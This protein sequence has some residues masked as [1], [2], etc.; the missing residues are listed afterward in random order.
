MT[1][2]YVHILGWILSKVALNTDP[3]ITVPYNMLCMMYI[4]TSPLVW[5]QKIQ[6][7]H[8]RASQKKEYLYI[9]HSRKFI[10]MW[11]SHCF[12]LLLWTHSRSL[13]FY[14][15]LWMVWNSL[16][17]MCSPNAFVGWQVGHGS[18]KWLSSEQNWWKQVEGGKWAD[19]TGLM[20]NQFSLLLWVQPPGFLY[21]LLK[22]SVIV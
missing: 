15:P 9:V 21:R 3:L 7:S 18:S 16:C 1:D 10:F 12:P 13:S 4:G 22:C 2:Q 11:F 17:G 19:T 20:K 5:S 8:L 6:Q 14:V